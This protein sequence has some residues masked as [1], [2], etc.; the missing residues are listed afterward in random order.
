MSPARFLV[1]QHLSSET[2]GLLGE[3]WR[4]AGVVLDAVELDAGERPPAGTDGYDALVVMGGPQDVWETDRFPWLAEEVDFIRQW[5]VDRERPF[6]GICLGHQLLAQAVGGTVG[7]A[8]TPEV[9][10]AEVATLPPSRRDALLAKA[11]ATFEC[12]QW[13]G[14]EVKALPQ[15]ASLLAGNAACAV[16][17]FRWG[18]TAYGFQY[19]VEVTPETV[20]LWAKEPTYRDALEKALW[21]GAVDY[22]HAEISARQEAFRAAAR[23]LADDFLKLAHDATHRV[24]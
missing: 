17:A 5:V 15:G 4:E 23:T 18:Q 9:G 7:P 19:H 10:V 16:Q 11:P 6:L 13:H 2:P 14:A 3:H 24:S 8:V 1:L 21:P 22:L 20:S 12:F